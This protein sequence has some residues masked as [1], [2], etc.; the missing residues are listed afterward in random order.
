M[1]VV[2]KPSMVIPE[3]EAER[4]HHQWRGFAGDRGEPEEQSGI[5][6]CELTFGWKLDV[7]I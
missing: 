7:L 6:G 5:S 3:C 2:E 4:R 1:E